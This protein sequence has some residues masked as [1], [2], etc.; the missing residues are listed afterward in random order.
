MPL[1]LPSPDRGEGTLNRTA[2]IPAGIG[3]ND[4]PCPLSAGSADN[5]QVGHSLSGVRDV[6]QNLHDLVVSELIE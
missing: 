6:T 3:K 1:T 2:R 4:L 5:D